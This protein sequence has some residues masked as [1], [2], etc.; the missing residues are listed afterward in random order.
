MEKARWG[1]R[2][3]AE[4]RARVA[5]RVAEEHRTKPLLE[6]GVAQMNHLAPEAI[7]GTYYITPVWSEQRLRR[8]GQS[9]AIVVTRDWI[10]AR[11][12]AK[13]A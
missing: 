13:N 10:E 2:S 7:A 5:Q 8:N 9:R 4:R 12:A 1:E 6:R 11:L 3:A